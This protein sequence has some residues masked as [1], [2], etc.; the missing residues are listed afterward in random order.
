M[1]ETDECPRP[2]EPV[3][4]FKITALKELAEQQTRFAPAARRQAQVA[5]ALRL[6]AEI[7]P[8]KGYPYQYICYRVTEY[9]ADAHADLVIA[10]E[11]LRH[12]Q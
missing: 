8:T 1:P 11:A 10:G 2:E 6:L 4:E 3:S 7:E 5:A 9:R 12:A